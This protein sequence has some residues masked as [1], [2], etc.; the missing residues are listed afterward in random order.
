[1]LLNTEFK[2]SVKCRNC[3]GPHNSE[4]RISLTC[5]P[6][7][8]SATKEYLAKI[9]KTRQQEYHVVPRTKLAVLRAEAA[10]IRRHTGSEQVDSRNVY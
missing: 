1:M 2:A 5:L 4:S 10:I 6:H 8:G 7:T 9:R 3:G